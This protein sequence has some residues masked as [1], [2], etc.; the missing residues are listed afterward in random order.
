MGNRTSKSRKKHTAANKLEFYARLKAAQAGHEVDMFSFGSWCR[1]QRFVCGFSDK[2]DYTSNRQSLLQMNS[3][4]NKPDTTEG[5]FFRCGFK[6]RSEL[7]LYEKESQRCVSVK[8]PRET[9]PEM[10]AYLRNH[11][12]RRRRRS[13]RSTRVVA[14]HDGSALIQINS[15]RHPPFTKFFI[16]NLEQRACC[17]QFILY[18]SLRRWFEV[19]I[20]PSST[21]IVL[22][23]DVRY[24]FQANINYHIQFNKCYSDGQPLVIS[25][26]Q[27]FL[28]HHSLTYNTKLGDEH[29][30]AAGDRAVKIYRT[31]DWSMTAQHSI[32][33]FNAS[34]QQI[35]SS[36]TGDYLAA[37]Y[38]YLADGCNYNCIVILS[39]PDF[40]KIFQVDIRGAYWP[41]SEL[42][43]LNIF[44][45][46]SLGESCL[47]VIKQHNF[48]R[49]IVIYKLPV[50]VCS[51]QDM[52]RRAILHLVSPIETSKLPIPVSLQRYL[53]MHCT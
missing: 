10:T 31:E 42:V 47:A 20:S 28:A 4:F 18:S 40:Q 22:R 32:F 15:D 3:S 6:T 48:G 37:R 23:P 21:H 46:F 33:S 26:V 8:L 38:N 16:I 1:Q 14:Y 7:M 24:H 9:C 19:Y 5:R 25:K 50:K 36:P 17:G 11:R 12:P 34:I 35:R 51:L 53:V 41:M 49:K 30:I 43:N 13:I 27:V 45:R 39:Y 29:I 44:P 52:C 2:A